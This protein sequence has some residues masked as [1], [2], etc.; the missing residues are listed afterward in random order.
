MRKLFLGL[1]AISAIACSHKQEAPAS[2]TTPTVKTLPKTLSEAVA[3]DRRTTKNK[4]RD[5]YR[6]PEQTLEFF[7]IKPDQTVVEIWPSGGW[8]TEILAPFLAEKGH[9]V[10]AVRNITL[11]DE[12]H[13]DLKRWTEANQDVASHISFVQFDASHTKLG[14]PN[15]ADR[16]VTFRNVHNW[17]KN[18]NEH[19]FFKAFFDVLKPGGILGVVEH[20]AN[21]NAKDKTGA[22]GYV[23]E[24][25]VIAMA[26]KA[27]FKFVGKSE[28]NAN[29]KD[30]KDYPDGVWDLP[31]SLKQGEVNKDKYVAIGE[32]DRMT[33]K[34]VKPTKK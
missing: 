25:A 3:G 29:P 22:S 26:K 9:Y 33:L 20:R 15:S 32:S 17:M 11:V 31:P 5:E 13:D 14:E 27:G 8:Y 16:V 34:F 19:K 2:P 4:L 30:T 10:G 7:E 12:N 24:D 18:K 1:V 21:K 28:I 6:H 23:S